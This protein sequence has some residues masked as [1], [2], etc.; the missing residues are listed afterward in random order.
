VSKPFG[1]R[2]E[3]L[4]AVR[5]KRGLTQRDLGAKCGLSSSV[6]HKYESGENDPT[7]GSLKAMA[8]NLGVSVDYLLGVTDDPTFQIREPSLTD[9]EH[10]LLDIYRLDGLPGLIR[11]IGDRMTK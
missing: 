8:K 3:R 1:L 4:R 10:E 2:V 5:V 9:E 7:G 11:F 6:I